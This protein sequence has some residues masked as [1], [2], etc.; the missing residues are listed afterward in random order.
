MRIEIHRHPGTPPEDNTLDVA[1]VEYTEMGRPL[2]VQIDPEPAANVI[3]REVFSGLTAI[4]ADGEVLVFNMRDSGFECVYQG[5]GDPVPFSLQ[6]GQ[7][8]TP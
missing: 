3:V 8:S 6:R 1:V 2:R 5:D 7:I 4:T